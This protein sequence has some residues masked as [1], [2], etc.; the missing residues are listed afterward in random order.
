MIT[1]IGAMN[2]LSVSAFLFA[3]LNVMPCGLAGAHSL[4]RPSILT[5]ARCEPWVFRMPH[6]PQGTQVQTRDLVELTERELH[7]RL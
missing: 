5:V 4:P 7:H 6:F 1:P 3:V 2:A